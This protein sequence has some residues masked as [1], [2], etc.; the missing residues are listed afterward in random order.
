M[1]HGAKRYAQSANRNAGL[2]DAFGRDVAAECVQVM[3]QRRLQVPKRL[4]NQILVRYVSH[5]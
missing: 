5:H 2:V 4:L 3:L 1:F